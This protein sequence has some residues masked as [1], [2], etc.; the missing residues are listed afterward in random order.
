MPAV[1]YTCCSEC[2]RRLHTTFYCRGCGQPS[3]SLDCY[4]RHQAGHARAR[5][6]AQGRRQ[7]EAPARRLEPARER[8]A[9]N[10]AQSS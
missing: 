1:G 4:C 3:C 7:V 10:L 2:G 6:T 9:V 8:G 5:E